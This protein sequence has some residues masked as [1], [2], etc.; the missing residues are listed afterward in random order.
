MGLAHRLG[1]FIKQA[2]R[3][4]NTNEGFFLF[5]QDAWLTGWWC[6][7]IPITGSNRT[8]WNRECQ[9]VSIV[10]LTTINNKPSI[11]SLHPIMA[12]AHEF[13]KEKTEKTVSQKL[14]NRPSV[15]PLDIIKS[16]RYKE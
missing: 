11:Q 1:Y 6:G 12:K 9:T 7:L 10:S 13:Q 16:N 14:N 5:L 2:K 15:Q 4:I 3:Y 8:H